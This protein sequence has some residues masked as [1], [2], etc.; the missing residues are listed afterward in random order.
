MFSKESESIDLSVV[1]EIAD[2]YV[3][4]NKCNEIDL[5]PA[6]RRFH[7]RDGLILLF[8]FILTKHT[9]TVSVKFSN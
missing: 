5:T 3:C 2:Y 7:T 6:F 4:H 1:A 8:R 9:P